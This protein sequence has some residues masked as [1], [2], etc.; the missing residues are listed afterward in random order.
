VVFWNC[1]DGVV[2][3][4]CSDGVVFLVLHFIICTFLY[5]FR[6]DVMWFRVDVLFVR[7]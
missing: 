7:Y 6:W 3:W 1:S 4:N 5:C 2:F